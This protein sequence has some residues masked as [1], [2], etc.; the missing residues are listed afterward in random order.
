MRSGGKI[1]GVSWFGAP[2][3]LNVDL[4]RERSLQYLF[5]DISTQAHF[6]HTLRLVA[7]GRVQLNP[8]ITH[9]L[10][11]LEAVPQA[12]ETTANK[13]KYRAIDPAQVFP[14]GQR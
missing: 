10:S 6:D 13:R 12:F 4:L 1:I 9:R 7:S 5:P 14:N 11:D 3:E 2:L 8:K